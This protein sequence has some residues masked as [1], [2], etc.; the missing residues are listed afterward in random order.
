[1]SIEFNS[2]ELEY[3]DD[4][5][6]EN[7][8]YENNYPNN[9]KFQPQKNLGESMSTVY[10]LNKIEDKEINFQNI[11]GLHQS[12]KF[13]FSDNIGGQI[14]HEEEEEVADGDK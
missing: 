14:L 5:D 9:T 6:E 12:Q 8:S 13:P 7:N 11:Q 4:S 1:M 10:S 3:N 2:N